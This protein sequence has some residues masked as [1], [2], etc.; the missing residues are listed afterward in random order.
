MVRLHEV[1]EDAEHAYIIMENCK[2]GDLETMLEVSLC[3]Q[4]SVSADRS[5]VMHTILLACTHRRLL[6]VLRRVSCFLLF[7]SRVVCPFA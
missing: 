3:T 2:G 5:T 7:L 1:Y 4:L 6:F